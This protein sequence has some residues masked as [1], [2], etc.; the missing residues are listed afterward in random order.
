MASS[1]FSKTPL[2]RW[3]SFVVIEIGRLETISTLLAAKI[4]ANP[5]DLAQHH[6]QI[7]ANIILTFARRASVTS[8]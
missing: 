8:I 3:A 1:D 7:M 2:P 5:F 6:G 4:R